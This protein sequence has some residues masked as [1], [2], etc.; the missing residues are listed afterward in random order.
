MVRLEAYLW[1]TTSLKNCSYSDN[2]ANCERHRE[3]GSPSSS[4]N[5]H[6]KELRERQNTCK[7]MVHNAYDIAFALAYEQTMLY[8]QSEVQQMLSDLILTVWLF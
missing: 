1:L 8:L 5:A 4:T 2:D 6:S 3:I 7:I